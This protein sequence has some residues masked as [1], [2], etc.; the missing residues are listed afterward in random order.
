MVSYFVAFS[1]MAALVWKAGGFL[2]A[3]SGVPRPNMTLDLI[4]RVAQLKREMRRDR[5]RVRVAVVGDSMVFTEG[6]G[7]SMPEWM[8]REL[9]ARQGPKQTGIHVLAFPAWGTPPEYSMVDDIANTRPDLLVLELNLRL[10]GPAPLG[11]VSY[12]ELSGH[13]ANDRL[14][15][16][17][18]LPLAHAGL[19]LSR[20]L[21]YR[22]IVL[23]KQEQRFEEVLTRQATL[24][25]ARTALEQWLDEKTKTEVYAQRRLAWGYA[26]SARFLA[27]GT[28]RSR[29]SRSHAYEALGDVID[30]IAEDHPRLV[31]LRAMLRDFKKRGVPVLVWASPINLDHLKRLGFRFEGIDR[32]ISTIRKS[33]EESGARFV[34]LHALLRDEDFTDAGDHYVR[35]GSPSGAE[36]VGQEL[37]VAIAREEERLALQ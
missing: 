14:L 24:L 16:A 28:T 26:L 17:A 21:F 7:V 8:K 32:S 12:P 27:R 33:V 31:V 35:E 34:D 5:A 13:I 36:R 18:F 2:V 22:A 25:D 3:L 37:G 15:E 20:M 19:T 9:A 30:G 6:P 29:D 11:I 10:L 4:P 1:A 23:A